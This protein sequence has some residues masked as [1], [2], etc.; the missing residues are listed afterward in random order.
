MSVNISQNSEAAALPAPISVPS[1]D[2]PAEGPSSLTEK[3]PA[4]RRR[5][6]RNRNNRWKPYSQLSWQERKALEDKETQ[7]HAEKLKQ[8]AVRIPQDKNG[9]VRKGVNIADY[10]PPTPHNTTQF[11]ISDHLG[12]QDPTLPTEDDDDVDVELGNLGGTMAGLIKRSSKTETA[13]SDSLE[14]ITFDTIADEN[15]AD[16]LKESSTSEQSSIEF[17][18][19]LMVAIKQK[20]AQIRQ[21]TEENVQLKTKLKDVGQPSET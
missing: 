16:I 12:F 4:G 3:S 21:L 13:P 8:K 5:S 19:S 17:I 7:K 11:I 15:V 18:K 20:D 6:R 14:S 2:T 1:T 9:R 10:R